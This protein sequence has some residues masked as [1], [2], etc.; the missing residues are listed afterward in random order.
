MGFRAGWS[1]VLQVFK[2]K[3]MEKTI[4]SVSKADASVIFACRMPALFTYV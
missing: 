2:C 4:C 1:A 3:G